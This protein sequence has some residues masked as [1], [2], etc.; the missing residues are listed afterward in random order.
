MNE[1]YIL[2]HEVQDFKLYEESD[3]VIDKAEQIKYFLETCFT[4]DYFRESSV[5]GLN[6]D[7]IED[8]LVDC[9]EI[10]KVW[11]K[12]KAADEMIDTYLHETE[13]RYLRGDLAFAIPKSQSILRMVEDVAEFIVERAET[14][15]PYINPMGAV[16]ATRNGIKSFWTAD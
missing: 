16:F 5:A 12:V 11:E 4:N 8:I 7:E 1:N 14:L 3:S 15:F 10:I 9:E 2:T 13:D 6:L